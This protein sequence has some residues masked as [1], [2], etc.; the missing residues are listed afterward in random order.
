M[1]RNEAFK[2]PI[3]TRVRSKVYTDG[4]WSHGTVVESPR[5][6]KGVRFDDYDYIAVWDCHGFGDISAR[7]LESLESV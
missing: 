4:R 6:G 3:D 1:N 2:L 5:Y 7:L